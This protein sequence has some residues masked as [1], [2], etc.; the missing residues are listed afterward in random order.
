MLAV[1]QI[2]GHQYTVSP[3]DVIKVQKLDVEEGKKIDD[4]KVLLFSDGKDVKV[5]KPFV[6]GVSVEMK[7]KSHGKAD[8]IRVFKMKAKKRYQRTQGHRQQFTEV[9]V[10]AIK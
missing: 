10:G 1:V 6:D 4:Y 3:Q 5:G 7:V 9:E 8:K 2:G